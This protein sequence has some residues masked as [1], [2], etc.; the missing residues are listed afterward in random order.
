MLY[1]AQDIPYGQTLS[2]QQIAASVGSPKAV[3]AAGSALAN[4]PLPILVPCHRVLRGDGSIGE[5]LGGT[6]AKEQLLLL[7]KNNTR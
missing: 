1:A 7:E 6:A 2:Y 5:Y 3:R 4:N